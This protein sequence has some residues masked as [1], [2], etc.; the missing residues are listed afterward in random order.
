MIKEASLSLS[1]KRH[2]VQRGPLGKES[3]WDLIRIP[4]P[5]AQVQGESLA[6]SLELDLLAVVLA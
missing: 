3:L 2:F 5:L 4:P 1:L 6:S